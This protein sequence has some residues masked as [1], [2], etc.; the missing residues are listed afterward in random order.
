[1]KKELKISS[2]GIRRK[3]IIEIDKLRG[4]EGKIATKYLTPNLLDTIQVTNLTTPSNMKQ[5]NNFSE[6][7]K[8]ELDLM[9]TTQNAIGADLFISYSHADSTIA[10]KLKA[11]LERHGLT[12][13][14]DT[15]LKFEFLFFFFIEKTNKKYNKIIVELEM[16]GKFYWKKI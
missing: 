3:I 13:W 4:G 12:C 5:I 6:A 11:D 1:M 10:L 7:V 2:A 14:M 8:N 16:I 9:E 15:H